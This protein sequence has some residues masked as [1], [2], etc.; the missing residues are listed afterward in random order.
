[1]KMESEFFLPRQLFPP[2][3]QV[4]HFSGSLMPNNSAPIVS[5]KLANC[6][7]FFVVCYLTSI[8]KTTNTAL[9]LASDGYSLKEHSDYELD[10][11]LLLIFESINDNYA[12]NNL[13]FI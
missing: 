3:A 2:M 7:S 13:D 4:F 11:K 10:V 6:S 1:M 5:G 12:K 9:G 8:Q